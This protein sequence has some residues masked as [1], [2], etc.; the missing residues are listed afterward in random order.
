MNIVLIDDEQ[1][2]KNLLPFCFT[3]PVSEI[4]I[5]ILNL[6]EKWETLLQASCSYQ[7]QLYLSQK[8]ALKETTNQIVIASN[9]CADRSLAKVI[10]AL[11][12]GEA[13]YWGDRLLALRGSVADFQSARFLK[14]V[15][16]TEKVLIL[17]ELTWPTG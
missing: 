13:L 16:L 4:R 3:R 8:Y 15:V 5:G 7:T 11:Q 1:N 14:K 9:L 10:K 12:P 17:A 2:W 6:R